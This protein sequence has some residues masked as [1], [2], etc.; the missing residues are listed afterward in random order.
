MAVD[1]VVLILGI[2]G[3]VDLLTLDLVL[4]VV[5]AVDVALAHRA[6]ALIGL[7]RQLLHLDHR[8][9]QHRVVPVDW[10]DQGLVEADG[11]HHHA[12][13]H[14]HRRQVSRTRRVL[15]QDVVLDEA[16]QRVHA[17]G[18]VV[19]TVT[20]LADILRIDLVV[21]LAGLLIEGADVTLCNAVLG[22]Q[23][24]VG[25]H[26]ERMAVLLGVGHPAH[27]TPG[28]RPVV[29]LLVLTG[30]PVGILHGQHVVV[31]TRGDECG[32]ECADLGIVAHGVGD[33]TVRFLDHHIHRLHDTVL[34]GVVLQLI[35]DVGGTLQEDHG[36]AVVVE[37]G[38]GGQIAAHQV[39]R[40]QTVLRHLH[41]G[42]HIG[43]DVVAGHGV[44]VGIRQ[45]VDA[46]Q[47]TLLQEGVHSVVIRHEAGIVTVGREQVHQTS[48]VD[49][50]RKLTILVA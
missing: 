48:P 14:F 26:E 10:V 34:H 33:V 42:V 36:I 5:A 13:I 22:L 50:G 41:R 3:R 7:H 37:A 40:S 12:D 18:Q 46:L 4:L 44:A 21:D 16:L 2:D 8:V 45:L 6:L 31:D 43:D 19:E 38:R 28:V 9:R 17:V 49:D 29:V 30:P 35:V 23:D 1:G 20:G 47:A 11:T 32:I 25:L 27:L 39:G 15:V 24:G